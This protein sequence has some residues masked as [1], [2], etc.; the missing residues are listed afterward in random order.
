MP[1]DSQDDYI[2]V[3]PDGDEARLRHDLLPGQQ[4]QET[5]IEV[6][7]LIQKFLRA[8]Y[9]SVIGAAAMGHLTGEVARNPPR[10]GWMLPLTVLAALVFVGSIG[11]VVV[12]ESFVSGA[13]LDRFLS[14]A[15]LVSLPFA[16]AGLLMLWRLARQPRG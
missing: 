15:W 12:W 7:P 6:D 9:D 13:T 1:I 8:P 10:S 4:E 2:L 16:V 5:L 14:P 11:W 3:F